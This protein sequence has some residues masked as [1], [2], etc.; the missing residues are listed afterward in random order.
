VQWRNDT[1]REGT[2]EAREAQKRGVPKTCSKR[3]KC[4]QSRGLK[5]KKLQESSLGRNKGGKKRF[6]WKRA[7]EG[8]SRDGCLTWQLMK[9]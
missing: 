2:R 3:L 9:A 7:R 1:E 4:C 5:D 6:C 8:G